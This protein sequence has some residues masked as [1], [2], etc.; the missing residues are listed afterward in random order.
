M[1]GGQFFRG[2]VVKVKRIDLYDY[3]INLTPEEFNSV[4]LRA[5]VNDITI[6]SALE[7]LFESAVEVI[8]DSQD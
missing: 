3:Q 4:K 7:I 6:E 1:D 8:S 2:N 5:K